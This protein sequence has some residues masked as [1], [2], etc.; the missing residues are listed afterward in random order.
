VRHFDVAERRRRL[1]TRQHL[2]TPIDSVEQVAGDLVGIHATDP[3][4]VY[5][6]LYNRIATFTVADLDAALFERRSL[7]R[8]L[9][10]RRTMFVVPLDLAAV[11]DAACTKAL[12]ANERRRTVQLMQA[13]GVADAAAVL[14]DACQAT[15]AVLRAADEPLAARSLTPAVPQLQMQVTMAPDKPYTARPA[16]TN[17]VLLHLS[18]EGHIVRTRPLGTWLSSQYRWTPT[19]RWFDHQ[20]PVLAAAD[21]RRDLV[22]RWLRTY[23]PGTTKDIAW[24]T[25]WTKRDVI[26]ALAEVGAVEVSVEPAPGGAPVAAWALADDVDDTPV[27]DTV[28]G[29]EPLVHLLPA[30]DSAIMGWKERDWYLGR[31]AEVLFDRNGNAG[32]LIVVDGVAVGAWAQRPGGRVVTE[33]LEP[34]DPAAAS[35]IAARADEL[36]AWFDGVRV[37]PRFPNPLERRLAKGSCG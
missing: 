6:S 26:A 15:L 20:R 10:M 16:I 28:G 19:E 8:V 24:W 17:R 12:V 35:R 34:V 25:K 9:G 18:T 23:G 31:H 21:A 30:L 22:E 33:L 36:T 1:L 3:A 14:E 2:A 4:T 32:P 29:G 27:D 5:L 11:V 7:T 37:T 13:E